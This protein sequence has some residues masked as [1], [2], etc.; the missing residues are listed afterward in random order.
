MSRPIAVVVYGASGYTG[1]FVAKYFHRQNAAWQLPWALA[2][3]S[4]HRLD[5]LLQ[6]LVAIRDESLPS[7]IVA[8]V[9]QAPSSLAFFKDV[10]LVLNCTGPFRFLGE[11][12]VQACVAHGTHYMDITGEPF[13]IE[14][15]FSKYYEEAKKNKSI[16]IHSCA[17]DSVPSDIGTLYTLRQFHDSCCSMIESFVEM[18]CPHGYSAHSTT[19]ECAV[20]GMTDTESL[21]Q[22]RKQIEGSLHPPKIEHVGP[23][24]DRRNGFF[25]EERVTKHCL[26]FMGSD[27]SVVRLTQRILA[28][29]RSVL[30]WP[31]I[32]I[33]AA[34]RK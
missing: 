16:V 23:K 27:A 25:F 28:M 31:Q 18:E 34:G 20:H 32:A 21:K 14:S 10:R 5:S 13:F 15:M 29:T 22:L 30:V 1:R 3:R 26:P 19:Y 12:I 6:E 17:F 4:E 2:G 33:Y 11:P 24:L 7:L 8:D 9:S